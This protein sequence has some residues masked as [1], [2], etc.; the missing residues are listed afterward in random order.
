[1][2]NTTGGVLPGGDGF[3]ATL[4]GIGLLGGYLGDMNNFMP[5][6]IVTAVEPAGRRHYLDGENTHKE[7]RRG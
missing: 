4:I 7:Y 1:M 5:A 6:F 2:P 3:R